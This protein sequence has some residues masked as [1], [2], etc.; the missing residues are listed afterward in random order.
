M[1]VTQER[2]CQI[3][4]ML[5]SPTRSGV[6]NACVII[7]VKLG[8]PNLASAS[9]MVA[10]MKARSVMETLLPTRRESRVEPMRSMHGLN[11][12]RWRGPSR[13]RAAESSETPRNA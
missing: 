5:E 6:G 9:H 13:P 8:R 1:S 2:A 11:G 3:W 12:V 10:L 7:I 4:G